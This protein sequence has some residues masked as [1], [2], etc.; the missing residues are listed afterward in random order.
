MVAIGNFDGVHKGHQAL[1]NRAS[2]I[3]RG[4]NKKLAVLTF[5]PH[6]RALFRPDEPPARLT[7]PDLK[8]DRL[9][10]CGVD[11][12]Y[13]LNFDWEFASLSAQDFI[14]KILKDSLNAAH[15]VVGYDFRFG[16]LRKGAPTDISN[17]G[18]PVSVID[19]VKGAD[20]TDYSSSRI[21]E[22]LRTGDIRGAN[23]ILGWDW[24]IR[25]E[26][27]RGDGR[28]KGLGYPTA[29]MKMGDFVHPAYG[30]Y[31][32]R[33]CVDGEDQW[34]G[35][36]INIGIRPMFEIPEAEVESFI[37]DFNRDLYGKILHVRPIER[38]RGEAKF[39]SVEEL[40]AQ[41]AKD[42]ENA[43]KILK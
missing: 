26:V 41:M 33:V 36:A 7:P 37:F 35:A 27:M 13:S 32:A 34:H 42:C 21:R 10:E 38:L 29:N 43:I 14:E 22:C 40:K 8:A 24:E 9:R 11:I 30:V 17:A 2:E 6:P 3:A 15:V 25:G 12:L 5:E 4:A 16:Q 19:A 18:I 1:I 23:E 39:A 31:A 20:G 28:G